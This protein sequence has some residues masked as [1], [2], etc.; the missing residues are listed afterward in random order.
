MTQLPLFKRERAART[1]D[2]RKILADSLRDVSAE[3][4]LVDPADLI[5]F[6]RLGQFANIGDLVNSSAEL[7]FKEGTLCFGWSANVDVDWD[8]PP[9]IR[10]EM[11][12]RNKDV[13]VFFELALHRQRGAVAVR[14]IIFEDPRSVGCGEKELDSLRAAVLDALLPTSRKKPLSSG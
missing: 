13:T 6:A 5:A 10:L 12:F 4:S 14:N 3:L 2:G 9:T 1:Q 11:E 8:R 7:Y